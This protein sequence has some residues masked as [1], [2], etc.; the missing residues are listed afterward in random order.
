MK[1]QDAVKWRNVYFYEN[2]MKE[3]F[4]LNNESYFTDFCGL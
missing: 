4:S 1:E 2:E 3:K